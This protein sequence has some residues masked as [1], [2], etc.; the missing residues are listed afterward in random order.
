MPLII[1]NRT[2][3]RRR[4]TAWKRP[5]QETARNRNQWR[6]FYDGMEELDDHINHSEEQE[7]DETMMIL[8]SLPTVKDYDRIRRHAIEQRRE[9]QRQGSSLPPPEPLLKTPDTLILSDAD[10]DDSPSIDQNETDEF[11]FDDDGGDKRNQR[12]TVHHPWLCAVDEDWIAERANAARK[13]R[14]R[15][16]QPQTKKQVTSPTTQNPDSLSANPSRAEG[17]F[18]TPAPMTR[19]TEQIAP[20]VV[21]SE[22]QAHSTPASAADSCSPDS[23]MLKKSNPDPSRPF[24]TL[25]CDFHNADGNTDGMDE[26]LDGEETEDEESFDW[27]QQQQPAPPSTS[28]VATPSDKKMD[29]DEKTKDKNDVEVF[30]DEENT[31]TDSQTMRALEAMAGI[32]SP[33][34]LAAAKSPSPPKKAKTNNKVNKSAIARFHN[35][36][37]DSNDSSDVSSPMSPVQ[38]KAKAWFQRPKKGPAKKKFQQQRLSFGK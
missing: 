31:P 1:D 4:G 15:R 35:N 33:N 24:D 2:P 11:E 19:G 21:T 29:K 36:D 6:P 34:D 38:H 37:D 16:E 22:K 32:A 10:D 26:F 7:E 28:P 20:P 9:A 23:A 8:P 14:Q 30:E 3:K 17:F 27:E 12:T 13:K 5:L 18:K 25:E